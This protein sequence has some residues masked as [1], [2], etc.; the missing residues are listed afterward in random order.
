MDT[1]VRQTILPVKIILNIPK[2]YNFRMKN[3]EISDEKLNAFLERYAKYN[4]CINRLENDFGPG[5]KLLGLLTTDIL[6]TIDMTD[7]YIVLVDDDLIY[8]PYMIEHVNNCINANRAIEVAS[9]IT[10]TRYNICIGQGADGFFIKYSLLNKFLEYYNCIKDQPYVNYHDDFYISYYFNLLNKRIEYIAPPN[11][12]LIYE[13]QQ[14]WDT[15]ALSK[16][17]GE[18]EREGLNYKISNILR[19][20]KEKGEF[21][22]LN[23]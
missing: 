15:D 6:K 21:N 8:K 3:L 13:H 10:Y 12:C 4:V 2:V 22:C 5:T 23:K 9:Y 18:Y 16:L 1:I 19:S 14:N 20:L 17:T 7:M 11:N